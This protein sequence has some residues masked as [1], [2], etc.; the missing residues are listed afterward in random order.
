[1]ARELPYKKKFNDLE[2]VVEDSNKSNWLIEKEIFN[3]INEISDFKIAFLLRHNVPVKELEFLSNS[4]VGYQ[5]RL[6]NFIDLNDSINRKS[7]TFIVSGDG[8]AFSYL[9]RLF[10]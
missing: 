9:P 1:M 4:F 10:L 3:Q 5:G 8:G 2:I 7:E 6:Q